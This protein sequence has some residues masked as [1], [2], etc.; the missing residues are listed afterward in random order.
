MKK[1]KTLILLLMVVFVLT[2]CGKK[3]T[4]SR[5]SIVIWHDKEEAVVEVL[6]K[7]L[8]ETVPEVDVTF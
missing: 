5:Q 6:E 7:H 2:G 3:N 4:S 8:K 1:Y